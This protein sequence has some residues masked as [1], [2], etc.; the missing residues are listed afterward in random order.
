[1]DSSWE[2]DFLVNSPDPW[3]VKAMQNAEQY[4]NSEVVLN[5]T[6]PP[7]SKLEFCVW[8]GGEERGGGLN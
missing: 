7:F 2:Y 3:Q 5:K 4:S 1:M 8:W 6:Y